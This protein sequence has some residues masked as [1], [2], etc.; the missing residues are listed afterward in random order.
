MHDDPARLIPIGKFGRPHGVKGEVRLW[1][2]NA[3]SPLYDDAIEGW[4]GEGE[5][6][7]EVRVRVTR[8]TDRFAIA[9]VDGAR[10][11][12]QA[13]ELTNL[14]LFVARDALPELDDD[15]LYLIDT[16]G[17]PVWL[18]GAGGRRRHIGEVEEFIETGANEV[19]RVRL[20]DGG[21]LLAPVLEHCVLEMA[22]ER[23]RVVLA[24]LDEWAPE[25]TEVATFADALEE[26]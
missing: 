17:W 25:G 7:R 21:S 26:E 23:A 18:L 15:E 9:R 24:P 16:I 3:D 22:P 19:M 20:L 12:D 2:Y 14:E 10:F 4:A 5:R 13:A 6:R 8:W 11:R 1:A